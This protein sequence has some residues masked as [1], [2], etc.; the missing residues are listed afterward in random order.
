[1]KEYISKDKNM[2][3]NIDQ[4]SWLLAIYDFA[5]EKNDLISF[6]YVGGYSK[7][8]NS[9]YIGGLI[10]EAEEIVEKADS[11]IPADKIGFSSDDIELA[12]E[13]FNEFVKLANL[14]DPTID[15]VAKLL[16]LPISLRKFMTYYEETIAMYEAMAHKGE[17]PIKDAFAASFKKAH[18]TPFNATTLNHLARNADRSRTIL[19][20]AQILVTRLEHTLNPA[21]HPLQQPKPAGIDAQP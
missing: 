9:N 8:I 15:G 16:G 10:L 5:H 12:R 21:N 7:E 4:D 18:G 6:E 2:T 19:T 17:S 1:M 13:Q 14:T 3:L 11:F 20:D